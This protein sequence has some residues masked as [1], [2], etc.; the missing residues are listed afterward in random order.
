MPKFGDWDVN[1]PQS[2]EFSVIFNKA[3]DEKKGGKPEPK[4]VAK[5]E[6]QTK[7]EPA[8]RKRPSVS[9]ILASPC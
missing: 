3:S 4:S 5:K 7:N 1:N 6:T 8:L 2:A 9:Y